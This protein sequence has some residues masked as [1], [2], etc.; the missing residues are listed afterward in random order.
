MSEIDL[1]DKYGMTPR[2]FADKHLNDFKIKRGEIIPKRCPFCN[3]T[4]RDNFHTFAIDLDSGAY[5]CK[6]GKCGA[7]GSFRDLLEEFNEINPIDRSKSLNSLTNK[8]KTYKKPDTSKTSDDL[9]EDIVDWFDWRGISEKTLEKWDIREEDGNVVFPYLE[10]GEEVLLKYR[11]PNRTKEDK[12]IWEAGGGK[13]ILWGYDNLNPDEPIVICEGELDALALTEA[14]VENVT[15]VPFGTEKYNWVENCWDLLEDAEEITL[16]MDNDDPGRRTES[17]LAQRVGKWKVSVVRSDY[18]DPN[19]QLVKEDPESVR[20]EVENAKELGG[21]KL[22]DLAGVKPFDFEGQTRVPSSIQQI[23]SI[24]GGYPGGMV[25][26]WTGKNESGKTTFLSQEM[27]YAVN[28]GFSVCSYNGE[29]THTKLKEWTELQMAGKWNIEKEFDDFTGNK[30]PVVPKETRSK[31]EDWYSGKYWLYE[32]TQ[33]IDWQQLLESFK[34]AARRYGV[35]LFLID[36]IMS[37]LTGTVENYYRQQSEFVG[38]IISFAREFEV[39]VMLVAH[40]KKEEGKLSKFDILG[41]G[42][43]SNRVDYVYSIERTTDELIGSDDNDLTYQDDGI[44]TLLKDR[45]NGQSD[46]SVVFRYDERSRR[47]FSKDT[48]QRDRRYRWENEDN[49]YEEGEDIAPF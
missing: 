49:G 27:G 34:Y 35:K 39:H 25:S 7:K 28:E 13:K 30:L 26:V 43:I 48:T 17:E 41:S 3:P 11:V 15:S 23:N 24:A 1:R 42:D 4:K 19:R 6:R 14:G 36:N 5:N 44:I 45:P 20:Q 12:K 16:W 31:I 18:K 40:P 22:I 33:G 32:T 8:S 46:K 10:D 9:S 21:D 38:E 47:L 2:Q 29:M 37:A